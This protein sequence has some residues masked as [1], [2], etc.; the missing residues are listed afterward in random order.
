MADSVLQQR[1]LEYARLCDIALKLERPLGFGSDGSVWAS[2]RDS[3]VK[4]FSRSRNYRSEVECYQRLMDAGVE[5]IDEFTVPHLLG[6]DDDLLVIEIEI[7]EPPYLIDFGKVSLDAPPD[8]PAEVLAE[9]ER[10]HAER[11]SE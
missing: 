4:A 8:Y 2:N 5:K 3:A 11:L 9:E 1:A 6:H 7:V 10:L